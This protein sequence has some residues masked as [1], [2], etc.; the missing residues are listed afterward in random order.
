[1]L[2]HSLV[3]FLLVSRLRSI[4]V[5]KINIFNFYDYI[6]QHLCLKSLVKRHLVLDFLLAFLKLKNTVDL[7][8]N[9]LKEYK[10]LKV[11]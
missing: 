6:I 5:K 7:F 4:I 11:G 2:C 9:V 1:M 3:F 8:T 10:N